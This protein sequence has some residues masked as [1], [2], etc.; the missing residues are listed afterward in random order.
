MALYYREI[1]GKTFT[2]GEKEF[3]L[4]YDI[5]RVIQSGE[6]YVVLFDHEQ[7]HPNIEVYDSEGNYLWTIDDIIEHDTDEYFEMG[8]PFDDVYVDMDVLKNLIMVRLNRPGSGK[9]SD[10]Y[11]DVKEKRLIA[12]NDYGI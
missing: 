5:E 10:Y 12:R 8:I 7:T 6:T 11:I 4:K 2:D 3:T 9:W 1:N